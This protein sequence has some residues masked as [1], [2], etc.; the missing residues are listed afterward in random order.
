MDPSH[1]AALPRRPSDDYYT[2]TLDTS[3]EPRLIAFSDFTTPS[4]A[5]RPRR[6]SLLNLAKSPEV[7]YG[8]IQLPSDHRRNSAARSSS[9]PEAAAGIPAGTRREMPARPSWMSPDRPTVELGGHGARMLDEEEEPRPRYGVRADVS[10]VDER[11]ISTT[12]PHPRHR[13]PSSSLSN[14]LRHPSLHAHHSTRPRLPDGHDLP[15]APKPVST[16]TRTDSFLASLMRAGSATASSP[17]LEREPIPSPTLTCASAPPPDQVRSNSPVYSSTS[18]RDAPAHVG[19][20]N[21]MPSH[22]PSRPSSRA[23]ADREL[24]DPRLTRHLHDKDSMLG[25]QRH[26]DARVGSVAP[27]SSSPRLPDFATFS[28]RVAESGRAD[29]EHSGSSAS[30]PVLGS[31]LAYPSLP[32]HPN[33]SALDPRLMVPASHSLRVGMHRRNASGDQILGKRKGD[34]TGDAAPSERNSHAHYSVNHPSSLP[35]RQPP[36]TPLAFP[37]S[38]SA[39]ASQSNDL[40]YRESHTQEP[41]YAS[42]TVQQSFSNT[43]YQPSVVRGAQLTR[44]VERREQHSNTSRLLLLHIASLHEQ[45]SGVHPVATTF[46]VSHAA[47]AQKSYGA[48]KRF[49]CPPP[50]V[51]VR[52]AP[53]RTYVPSDSKTQHRILMRVTA[54]GPDGRP[55]QYDELDG[56]DPGVHGRSV[57]AEQLALMRAD[58]MWPNGVYFLGLHVGGDMRS[59]GA[60]KTFKLQVEMLTPPG[61]NAAHPSFPHGVPNTLAGY[62][63]RPWASF[64]SS[65]ISVISKPARKSAKS[66]NTS[67]TVMANSFVCLYNRVNSQTVR[68]RFLGIET[69]QSRSG[70]ISRLTAK[71]DGWTPLRVEVIG[72]PYKNV[73]FSNEPLMYGHIIVLR[74]E[75]GLSSDPLLVCRVDKGKVELWDHAS[76]ERSS[77]SVASDGI[78]S[79][80]RLTERGMRELASQAPHPNDPPR[81]GRG[82]AAETAKI[83]LDEHAA[84]QRSSVDA[85][86]GSTTPGVPGQN[87]SPVSQMQKVALLRILPN[88]VRCDMDDAS[89]VTLTLPSQHRNYLCSTVPERRHELG[90]QRSPESGNGSW[91]AAQRPRAHGHDAVTSQEVARSTAYAHARCSDAPPSDYP[92][93]QRLPAWSSTVEPSQGRE[94]A[95]QR[96][97]HPPRQ[98]AHSASHGAAGPASASLLEATSAT[99]ATPSKSDRE[100]R[101]GS[102]QFADHVEVDVVDDTLCW[103]VVMVHQLEYTYIDANTALSG[104]GH[105]PQPISNLP[106]TPFSAVASK[107]FF[108]PT[109]NRL[110]FATRDLFYPFP[111]DDGGPPCQIAS[112]IWIGDLG[113]LRFE[114]RGPRQRSDRDPPPLHNDVVVTLPP[115]DEM[116]GA[117]HRALTAAYPKSSPAE[118]EEISPVGLPISL[119]RGFDGIAY[120]SEYKIF[121]DRMQSS[122]AP[123]AVQLYSIRIE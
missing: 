71:M 2:S 3:H 109:E 85:G 107:P 49:L 121:L 56:R 108:D 114:V 63:A 54:V 5:S 1:R 102:G 15:S 86:E 24:H 33:A 62:D 64:L 32:A 99:Y 41:A 115:P 76:G 96:A 112:E 20:H 11:S 35:G 92:H 91:T 21:R 8:S 117:V 118:L 25:M 50:S 89:F 116:A 87:A 94:R 69:E 42:P 30:T 9:R 67:S 77:S 27:L 26:P 51:T 65:P 46:R 81:Y 106:V 122:L 110:N 19:I 52:G 75:A 36:P 73:E 14:G 60:S 44:Q 10:S 43:S 66:R 12:A 100:A 78:R 57:A 113:P 93:K 38:R 105:Q 101:V 18:G 45:T 82:A 53:L 58:E 4:A 103:S 111:M 39:T 37:P 79:F 90:S 17:T 84:Q 97:S 7:L 6:P 34:W 28:R 61:L 13:S 59:D 120:P 80:F 104:P 119:V 40:H 83:A 48:E 95:E 70:P 123:D 47:V 74:D 16:P 23:S 55:T 31:R 98:S 88:Y 29:G 68:T 22:P 72:R